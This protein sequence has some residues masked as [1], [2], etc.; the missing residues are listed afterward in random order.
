VQKKSFDTPDTGTRLHPSPYS[1]KS[2]RRSKKHL[3]RKCLLDIDENWVYLKMQ[4]SNLS[5]FKA[6]GPIVC[7]RMSFLPFAVQDSE[8]SIFIPIF[9]DQN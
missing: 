2:S 5:V 9:A 6:N 8:I 7:S 1:A 3:L 4:L